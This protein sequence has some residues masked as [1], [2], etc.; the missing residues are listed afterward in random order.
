MAERLTVLVVDDDPHLRDIVRF[1]LEQGG[2]RVEEAADGR[3]AVEQV[4]RSP[5]ALIVL[6]IMMP[7]MDGL[8]VCREVRR[9]H[10]LPIVFLSS[11][12]DE[13]DRILGLELGGDDYLTKPFSPRELVA[14]VKAVLRRARPATEAAPASTSPKPLT[15]GPL[16]L[17]EERFRAWW[18]EQEV[19]LTVT[20]FHLLA[21]LLRVPGKVFTRDE[22]MTRVY[23]DGVVSD[24]TIDSHVRRVR[25]KFAGVGGEVIETVHGLGYRLAIP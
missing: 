14:R 20:E 17:D 3:A 7:E 16:K 18:G 1:A 5:P 2:F 6:D 12:D 10:E 11:R 4:R 8:A 9:A 13:V 22:V 24:R 21:A 23:D 25:Q 15:R 19:V